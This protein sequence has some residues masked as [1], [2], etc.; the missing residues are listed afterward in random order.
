MYIIYKNSVYNSKYL[1][2]AKWNQK[3]S[4]FAIATLEK[5]KRNIL[6]AKE[7]KEERVMI[8]EVN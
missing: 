7:I 3:S 6:R 1:P 4:L 2:I 8:D 5:V